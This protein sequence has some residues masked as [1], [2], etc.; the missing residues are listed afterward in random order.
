[1]ASC[2]IDGPPITNSRPA[3]K[4]RWWS[5]VLGQIHRK[6]N[7]ST[8]L[9]LLFSVVW[10]AL[11]KHG[12]NKNLLTCAM[13]SCSNEGAIK[14]TQQLSLKMFYSFVTWVSTHGRALEFP[15]EAHKT[16]GLFYPFLM[17]NEIGDIWWLTLPLGSLKTTAGA[18]VV[19]IAPGPRG[20]VSGTNGIGTLRL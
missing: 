20:S 11:R 9:F 1:M 16:W 14:V 10:P 4:L 18:T 8:N 17:P 2:G 5:V 7:C 3:D 15:T 19:E 6:S 13:N 12:T